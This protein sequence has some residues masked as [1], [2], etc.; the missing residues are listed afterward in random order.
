M[1]F[2]ECGDATLWFIRRQPERRRRL[3]PRLFFDEEKDWGYALQLVDSEVS[4][5]NG[6]RGAECLVRRRRGTLGLGKC[7]NLDTAWSWRVSAEGILF[8]G[9]EKLT[10]S[11]CLWRNGTSSALS[12]CEDEEDTSYRLARFSMVRYHA[13]TQA[14]PAADVGKET[15]DIKRSEMLELAVVER[16][17]VSRIDLAHSQA[18]EPLMHTKLKPAS[19]LL[20]ATLGGTASKPQELPRSLL[21]AA[22]PM[23]LVLKEDE[24]PPL[25]I[26]VE[27][28]APVKLRKMPVHPYIASA[29]D[30]VWTDPQTD[31]QYPT[32][33]CSYLGYDR[34]EAG[35]HTLTG[36]GQYMRTVFNVKV[37]CSSF[38]TSCYC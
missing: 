16:H 7:R 10:P 22:S 30:E 35:R 4:F 5:S 18:S 37:R 9:G 31:L 24:I 2:S 11:Q 13:S 20:F 33:L 29:K 32:D 12:S 17:P 8:H 28:R 6:S 3:L 23:L 19:H 21:K 26:Q 38:W 27:K 34:K 14:P 36:V 25:P 15:N 1:G